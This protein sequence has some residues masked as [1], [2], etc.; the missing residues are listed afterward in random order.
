MER[1]RVV[2]ITGTS[3]GIGQEAAGQLAGRGWTVVGASRRGTAGVGWDP[4][5]MD[6]DDDESV[7]SGVDGV[8]A[9][10]GRLDAVVACAGWGL[11]GPVEQTPIGEAK[12]QV[13]TNFWGVVRVV[14]AALPVM[15]RQGSGRLVLVSSIGGI[16]GIPFQAYYSASKFALEGYGESLAYEVAPFGIEVTLI[17]PGNVRTEFTGSRRKVVPPGGDDPYAAM[18][19]KAVG[20]MERDEANGV[21]ASDVAT[22]IAQVLESRRPR[23]RVSVGKM[24]ERVGIIAKRLIPFRVFER[25]AKGSLGV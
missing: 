22:V 5:V 24:G 7:Q 21:P 9:A 16:V 2:L 10:H 11:S 18:V 3:A 6:V 13:E 1:V 20:L 25:A 12:A 19:T 15:R 4:L 23:R 14:Q 17:E 8:M